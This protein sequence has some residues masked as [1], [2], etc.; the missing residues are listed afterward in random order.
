MQNRIRE[1][2][3]EKGLTLEQLADKVGGVHFTTIGKLETGKMEMTLSRMQDL[4]RALDVSVA[5]LYRPPAEVLPEASL[6]IK[7]LRQGDTIESGLLLNYGHLSGF[8]DFH[9]GDV[10]LQAVSFENLKRLT[11]VLR[12]SHFL[13][14][15]DD[16]EL[17]SGWHY[18][19]KNQKGE[20]FF[21][22]YREGPSRFVRPDV[23]GKF[24]DMTLGQDQVLI[25][26]ICLAWEISMF[27]AISP[28]ELSAA[29]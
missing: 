14:R 25:L 17:I 28:T 18:A 21:A 3:L 5:D 29:R 16:F 13:L 7:Y 22:E 24:K 12:N 9:L 15:T 8:S 10:I 23:G 11:G 6:P 2:R 27:P 19:V 26:G 1:I 20:I 4:A